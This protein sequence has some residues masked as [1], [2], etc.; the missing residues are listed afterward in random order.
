MKNFI[1]ISAPSGSGK[2]SIC[3]EILIHPGKREVKV[4]NKKIELTFSE[5]QILYLLAGRPNIVFTRQQIID[6]IYD[7]TC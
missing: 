1:I 6:E 4:G 7:I 5:F 3:K 2:T